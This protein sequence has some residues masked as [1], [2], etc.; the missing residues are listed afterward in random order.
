MSENG[1]IRLITLSE[2]MNY[3]VS[4]C[5]KSY[6]ICYK[7]DLKDC[8]SIDLLAKSLD[9]AIFLYI[10]ISK[11]QLNGVIASIATL[12]IRKFDKM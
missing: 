10:F 8:N 9:R 5:Q 1:K 3:V 7:I 11:V 2:Y 12:H 6:S 4:L